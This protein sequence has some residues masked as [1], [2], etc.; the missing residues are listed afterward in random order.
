MM[1]IFLVLFAV[2][3]VYLVNSMGQKAVH[4]RSGVVESFISENNNSSL[5]ILRKRYAEGEIS[6]IEYEDIRDALLED[7]R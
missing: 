2:G 7:D 4:S 6:F 3:A 1:I 5:E